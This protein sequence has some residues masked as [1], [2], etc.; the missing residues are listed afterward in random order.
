MVFKFFYCTNY[1]DIQSVQSEKQDKPD[2]S[3]LCLVHQSN[4][5]LKVR[6]E[7]ELFCIPS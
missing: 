7:M 6:I 5:K 4:P 1:R 2:I 3:V